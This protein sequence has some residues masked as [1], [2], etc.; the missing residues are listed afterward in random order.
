MPTPPRTFSDYT[1]DYVCTAGHNDRLFHEFTAATWADPLLAPHRKH[2]E[3]HKLGFGDA[4]FHTMWKLLLAEAARRFGTVRCLEIGVFKG[5]VISL[6]S[7]L[8]RTQ[9]LDVHVSALSPLAGQPRPHSRLVHALRYRLDRHYRERIQNG[10]FYDND[11]YE[12][13]V[14]GLFTHFGLDFNRV[15]LHRG[16][17][18]A[19]DI[20]AG[21]ANETFHIIYVD[22]DHTYD[23]ALHDFKTFGPKVVPGGW[24]I[25]DDAGASL[26]GT[27]FWKGH[28]AVSRAAEVLPSLG[29]KNVLN[30]SHNRVFERLA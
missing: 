5:Q 11:E 27:A 17:S 16:Y 29:F 19:P 7:H 10:D 8:A 20:L 21:L 12:A 18:T 24:L 30:I 28:E 22:G 9:N 6:W 26:P 2:I 3:E 14:R 4:A 15:A 1:R 25:A 23:G 13:I